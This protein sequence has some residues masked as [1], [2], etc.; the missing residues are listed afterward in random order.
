LSHLVFI[1]ILSGISPEIAVALQSEREYAPYV[2]RLSFSKKIQGRAGD[3]SYSMKMSSLE[4]TVPLSLF[5]F[6][7]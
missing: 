2:K 1:S 3:Y 5:G 6:R 4:I 7:R